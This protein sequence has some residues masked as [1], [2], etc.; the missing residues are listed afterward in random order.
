MTD[1]N[2]FTILEDHNETVSV[3]VHIYAENISLRCN[4]CHKYNIF[5]ALGHSKVDYFCRA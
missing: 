2:I 4:E 3:Y 1:S 5:R